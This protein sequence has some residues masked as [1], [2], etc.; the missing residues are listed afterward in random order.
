MK[1]EGR[2]GGEGREREGRGGKRRLAIRSARDPPPPRGSRLSRR[3]AA[4]AEGGRLPGR[5]GEAECHPR[6]S[7]RGA[8]MKLSG[9]EL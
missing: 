2:R 5:C 4:G 9:K 1:R 7:V 6:Y 8:G 3:W